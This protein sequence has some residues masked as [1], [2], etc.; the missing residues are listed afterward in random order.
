MHPRGWIFIVIG[1]L[2][3]ACTPTMTH[4]ELVETLRPRS[5][6]AWHA[7]RPCHLTQLFLGSEET[8]AGKIVERREVITPA[9]SPEVRTHD[10]PGAYPH[11]REGQTLSG[12]TYLLDRFEVV[13]IEVAWSVPGGLEG[14]RVDVIRY[15]QSELQPK[16]PGH[17]WFQNPSWPA[18]S[19]AV[20]GRPAVAFVVE[21]KIPELG[22]VRALPDDRYW[23]TDLDDPP[24]VER[25]QAALD[26]VQTRHLEEEPPP[27]ALG[28]I[29]GTVSGSRTGEIPVEGLRE[30]RIRV[31]DLIHVVSSPAGALPESLSVCFSSTTNDLVTPTGRQGVQTDAGIGDRIRVTVCRRR[32]GRLVG[33]D[34]GFS[35]ITLSGSDSNQHRPERVPRRGLRPVPIDRDSPV[36]N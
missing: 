34:D 23:I 11:L 27:G 12:R 31:L 32:D 8:V 36:L 30:G 26:S 20:V 13:T 16:V 24:A 9:M 35:V 14:S 7:D 10:I 33:C 4:E 5:S 28:W 22:N 15:R 6:F 2:S 25:I 1:L 17:R 21:T 19:D 29:A 3:P 18:R